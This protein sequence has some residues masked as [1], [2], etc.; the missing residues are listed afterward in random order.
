MASGGPSMYH[1]W[2]SMEFAMTT[3]KLDPLVARPGPSMAMDGMPWS[4]STGGSL[5]CTVAEP[6]SGPFRVS[7]TLFRLK[8]KKDPSLQKNSEN[9]CQ[10]PKTVRTPTGLQ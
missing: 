9:R 5:S 7:N 8:S 10:N 1:P 3:Y 6:L 2:P 4:L